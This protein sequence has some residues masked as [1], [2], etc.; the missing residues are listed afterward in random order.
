MLTVQ[1]RPDSLAIDVRGMP[2]GSRYGTLVPLS[3]GG[4]IE[5]VGTPLDARGHVVPSEL[6]GTMARPS[7]ASDDASVATVSATGLVRGTGSGRT[8]VRATLTGPWGV[9]RGALPIGVGVRSQ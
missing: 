4:V 2:P 7:F 9:I 1:Q 6:V 5:L 8:T 3:V